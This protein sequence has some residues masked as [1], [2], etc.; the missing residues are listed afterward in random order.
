MR[1]IGRGGGRE[2]EVLWSEDGVLTREEGGEGRRPAVFHNDF[3]CVL[4]VLRAGSSEEVRQSI[5]VERDAGRRLEG[6]V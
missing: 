1:G 5:K 4:C 2:A 6:K 3:L